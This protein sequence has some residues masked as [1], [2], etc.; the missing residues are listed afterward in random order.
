MTH[1]RFA[2]LAHLLEGLA[3]GAAVNFGEVEEQSP[4]TGVPMLTSN[5]SAD[6]VVIP[7]GTALDG[8]TR[9]K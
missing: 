8:S 1:L 9:W 6:M 3:V 7:V 4:T 5:C 2:L